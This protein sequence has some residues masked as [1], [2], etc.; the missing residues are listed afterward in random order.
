MNK[1]INAIDS[2]AFN[3]TLS[4]IQFLMAIY[5]NIANLAQTI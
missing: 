4:E 2:S 1:N 3:Y 5:H